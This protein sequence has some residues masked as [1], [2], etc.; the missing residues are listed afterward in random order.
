MD[1]DVPCPVARHN[2]SSTVA[3]SNYS[4]PIRDKRMHIPTADF[5]P[6]VTVAYAKWWNDTV[7]NPKNA[8][9]SPV[10]GPRNTARR[11]RMIGARNGGSLPAS[12]A[13]KGQFLNSTIRAQELVLK[14]LIDQTIKASE[15]EIHEHRPIESEN[16]AIRGQE[17]LVE[18]VEKCKD[19]IR[20]LSVP[21]NSEKSAVGSAKKAS[22]SENVATLAGEGSFVV[23]DQVKTAPKDVV[24]IDDDD[25]EE[26][27]NSFRGGERLRLDLEARLSRLE[28]VIAELK[29]RRNASF[30]GDRMAKKSRV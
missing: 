6:G 21:Q 30:S 11:P 18:S 17:V 24:I 12:P 9:T 10:K 1:Q 5:K 16:S 3:W 4:R 8:F 23:V 2:S 15:T 14:P 26:A 19:T 13:P 25:E 22:E 29:R 28:R 7:L 27:S 20:P